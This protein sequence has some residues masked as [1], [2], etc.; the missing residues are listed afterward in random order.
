MIKARELSSEWLD[1]K[2][3]LTVLNF[4][5]LKKATLVGLVLFSAVAVVYVKYVNRS[6]HIELQH[7]QDKRDKLHVEWTQLLLEQGTLGSDVRVERVAREHLGMVIPS[8]NQM[9]VIRP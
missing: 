2:L 5:L 3:I 7:L 4:E 8:P 9:I 1:F 6:M